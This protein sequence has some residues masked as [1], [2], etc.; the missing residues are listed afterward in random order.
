MN[1]AERLPKIKRLVSSEQFYLSKFLLFLFGPE[2]A[3]EIL[4]STSGFF[5]LWRLDRFEVSPR[6]AF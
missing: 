4:P 5:H 2:E 3:Q 6:Q 1:P